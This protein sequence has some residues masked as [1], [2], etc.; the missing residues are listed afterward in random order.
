VE[1]VHVNLSWQ[2]RM[3][4][5]A[6]QSESAAQAGLKPFVY[7]KAKAY[8]KK[9]SQKELRAL[10]RELVSMHHRVRQGRGE[11]GVALERLILSL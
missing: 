1:E 4:L 9:Y 3:M 6:S 11:L 7:N 8:A 2:V 10:S 5:L